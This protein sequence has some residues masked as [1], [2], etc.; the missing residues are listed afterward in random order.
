MANYKRGYPRTAA[1]SGG[2]SGGYWL[3]HWPRH[4]DV[5]YHTR[6]RRRRE[7]RLL[8]DVLCGR[9]DPDAIAWPVNHKPHVYYW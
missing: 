1:C 2:D 4:W 9:R 8:K 7:R 5:V 3:D 6:P